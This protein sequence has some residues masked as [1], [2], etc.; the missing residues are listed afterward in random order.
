MKTGLTLCKSKY[1]DKIQSL[2]D[3]INKYGADH[4]TDIA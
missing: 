3:L 1:A 2:L 4:Q